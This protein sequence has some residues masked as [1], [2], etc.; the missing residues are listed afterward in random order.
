MMN[1]T[2]HIPVLGLA[3]SIDTPIKVAQYGISSVVSIVDDIAIERIRK[4][5]LKK[6][7]KPYLE[8]NSKTD[9]TRAKRITAYLDMMQDLVD[10]EFENI[11]SQSFNPDTLL[12]KYFMLLPNECALKLEYLKMCAENDEVKKHDLQLNIK[13]KMEKGAIDVN[14]MPKVDKMNVDANGDLK[15]D[16][17]SDALAALR[18]FANSKLESSVVLSAGMNPR[19]YSYLESFTDFLPDSNGKLKKKVILKVSDFRSAFIQAKF[20]A[21][22]GIWISEFRI[23]S[24]LN[25]GGHAFATEG[26]L[27][28]PILE[29]FKQKKADMIIELFD[30]YQKALVLKFKNIKEAPRVK[31]SVQGGIGTATEDN[32]LKEYY[33]LDATGWGSPFLLVPEVTAVDE[34]TLQNLCIATEDDYY[35]SGASPLGIPFNNFRKSG[36]EKQRLQRIKDNKPGSPCTKKF[37]V[38]NTEFTTKPIC[39]A[40]KKYQSLKIKELKK[41]DLAPQDYQHKL[42]AITEKICLCEG[43]VNSYYKKNSML[44]TKDNNAVAICPSPNLA[45]FNSTYTLEQMVN[46]I[47]G[48]TNLLS[49]V[50]RSH[51]FINELKLYVE[52]LKKDIENNLLVMTT[53]KEKYLN[54]FYNQLQSGINYYRNLFENNNI[55]DFAALISFNNNLKDLE[56]QLHQTLTQKIKIGVI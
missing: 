56:N 25:C 10:E 27:L 35:V 43:L 18:G 29:E 7:D 11:K 6:N 55:I 31:I 37:L 32:F 52:Y 26:F 50:K 8:I 16:I 21:K 12:S 13:A 3:Y 5:Y 42:D 24:G 48:K 28:G 41:E 51:M 20:L 53:K 39:T 47:Y 49:G 9:D 44:T 36:S 1:H 33:Q 14:I 54:N 40:S 4:F 22:K 30:L 46:H 15:E 23:E 45:F 2:F 34:E 38:S 17:F 19:L